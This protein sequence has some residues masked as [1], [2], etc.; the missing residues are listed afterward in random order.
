[1]KQEVT[2]CPITSTATS[3]TTTT[4]TE[5]TTTSTT[6]TTELTTTTE[7]LTTTIATATEPEAI[8]EET[9]CGGDINYVEP[10]SG[11]WDSTWYTATALGYTSQPY[12]AS[13]NLLVSGYSVASDYF[14]YGT[15]LYIESEY[16]TGVFE[17]MDCGVGSANTVDFYFW[18]SSEVPAG[19]R[20]AG[21]V[22]ITIT[23]IE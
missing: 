4:T 23:I 16:M 9:V 17:V 13:G 5:T 15:L 18:D 7:Q 21:R 10:L 12:G 6:A 19:F 22:P 14:A 11:Y 1:M 20:Q 8:P 3:T 2:I